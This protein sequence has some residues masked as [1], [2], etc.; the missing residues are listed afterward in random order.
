MKF[1]N[2]KIDKFDSVDSDS[3]ARG[4]S[5]GNSPMSYNF[6]ITTGALKDGIGVGKLKFRRNSDRD[7]YK[8]LD[9]PPDDSFVLACWLYT[10]YT[11][12]INVDKSILVAYTSKGAIFYNR[13]HTEHTEFT[14][15]DGVT[16]SSQPV[17]LACKLDGEDALI[18]TTKAEGTYVWKFPLALEKIE[19]MPSIGS[20]CVHDERLF[21]TL[22]GDQRSVY[23][24]DDLNV[25]SLERSSKSNRYINLHDDYGCCNKVV[26]FDGY[27][28]VFKD[29]NICKI[30]TNYSD[31]NAFTINPISVSNGRIYEKTICICGDRIYYLS[32]DGLYSFDGDKSKRVDLSLNRLMEGIDNS[33]AVAGY[34]NGYYYLSC[35]INYEDGEYIDDED[36]YYNNNILIRYNIDSG[37]FNILRGRDV[38]GI[39]VINDIIES[40]VCVLVKEPTAAREM[41]IVDMSGQYYKECTTKVWSTSILDFDN[42][43]KSKLL[44][45][46]SLYTKSNI[47]IVI[48]TES[49]SRTFEVIG[50]ES[51]QS[52]QVN[53]KG[54]TFQCQFVSS[55]N[56]NYISSVNF[57]V[58]C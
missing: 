40:R 27:L 17:V 18:L 39:Y 5:I 2:Y 33:S 43:G 13:L 3:D 29:Y 10:S 25:E 23:Y 48:K 19:N 53:M 52:I 9:Y 7:V 12:G 4:L 24:S 42:P 46:L 47:Q 51:I 11:D 44:K 58:G 14:L 22:V 31:K 20:M 55:T 32:S 45:E 1:S 36:Y 35:R 6:D 8:E 38:I 57:V 16:F 54:K 15:L 41:G 56:N 30:T 37:K 28:Y 21:A 34:S 50:S 26:S 49:E